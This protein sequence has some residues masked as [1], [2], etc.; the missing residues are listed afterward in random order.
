MNHV[1]NPD[2]RSSASFCFQPRMNNHP[3]SK[4]RFAVWAAALSLASSLHAQTVWTGVSGVNVTTNWSDTANWST[5]ASPAGTDVLFGDVGAVA[6]AG[7][8]NSVVDDSFQNPFSLTFTNMSQSALFHTVFIPSGV[9]LNNAGTFTVGGISAPT[10]TTVANFAGGGTLVQNGAAMNVKWINGTAGGSIATLDL[11]GLSNFVYNAS[12]GIMTIASSASGA[13][14][15][16]GG[17]VTLAGVSNNITVGTIAM[18]LGTGNGGTAANALNLGGGT[19][20]INVGTVNVAAGKINSAVIKFAGAT[21][22]LRLRGV[23]GTDS[24]RANFTLGRRG[25]TG[26]GAINGNVILT[27][28][29]P[30]DILAD[31]MTLGQSTANQGGQTVNGNLAFDAGI[32]D[33]NNINLGVCSGNA[34]AIANGFVTVGG[35]TLKVANFSLVN[36]TLGIAAGTLSITNGGT[37]ICSGSILK[38]TTAGTGTI[39]ID[40]GNLS[41]SNVIGSVSAPVNAMSISNATLTI[42]AGSSA[43]ANVTTL[44][45][46]G[47]TNKINITEIPVISGYPAQFPVIKYAG[48]LGGAFNVGLG[49]LPASAPAFAG[50]I[51]NNTVN[52]SIDLV[53]T[54]GPLPARTISWRGTT[55]GNWDTT[56]P[57][58]FF[59]S[60]TTYN[61]ADFVRFDDAATRT[62][63]ILTTTLLPSSVTVSNQ[64]KAFGFASSGAIS[65]DT[66]LIKDGAATLFITN[67]GL[68][69]FSGTVSILAGTIQVGDGTALGNLGAGNIANSGT[70]TF[71]RPDDVTVANTISGTGALRQHGSAQL[72]V[73]GANTF[74]GNVVV[75]SGTLNT[76][77]NA[78]LGAT[79]GATTINSGATLDVNARNLGA[80]PVTVS[81]VGVGSGGAII[82]SGAQALNALR[83]VT[84]A[85]NT[86]FGGVGRWDIRAAPSTTDPSLA[87]LSTGGN[88]YSLTKIGANQISLVGVTVDPTLGNVD[89]Q[90]GILSLET[91]TT[92]LGNPASSLTVAAGASLQF[93]Q[94]TNQ[95][96][97]VISLASDSFTPSIVNNSGANTIIGPITMTTDCI[98]NVNGTSLNVAGNLSGGIL[99]K[100]GTGTLAIGGAATHAGTVVNVGNLAL[101]GT[102]SGGVTNTSTFAAIS[103][104][105]SA[106]GAVDVSGY[107]FPGASNVVGTLTVGELILQGGGIVGFDL[108]ASTTI[109]SGVN[110]LLVVNGNLTVNGNQININPQGLLQTGVPY[111]LFNYTGTLTE[112]SPFFVPGVNGYTFTVSTATPGQ[113]NLVASGGPPVWNGGSATVN[114]WSDPANWN[115]VT[116]NPND[117]L[118][119]AGSTRLNNINDTT[120]DTTYTDVVFN[121]GAGAFTLNGNSIILAGN[122]ANNSAN[123][124]KVNLG[125]SYNTTPRTLNGGSAGLIIG[126]GV[127]NAA[128]LTTLTLSG[129]GTLTNLLAS[130]DPNTMTNV[131]SMATNAN[132]TL[133]DNATATAVTVP[134]NFQI[135]AGTLNFGS[136]ASAPTLTSTTARGAPGDNSL[137]QTTGAS[138]TL[139][140]NNGILTLSARLNTGAAGGATGIV[141]V[142]NGTLNVDDQV[143]GAN[144]A[145][146]SVSEINVSGGTFNVGGTTV[147]TA[148][149]PLYVASRG[150]GSLTVSGSGALNCGILDV[151]RSI[152]SSI[153]GVVNLDGGTITATRVGT[154]TANAGAA[155]TG[156]TATF[157]FNGGTLKA[158][159]TQAGFIQ[160][161]TAAPIIPVVCIVKSGGAIIDSAGFNVTSVEALQHDS[162]LGGTPDGGLTKNGA[163]TL[164]LTAAS[165]YTGPTVINNGVLAVN[166][167]LATGA[168]S[169]N[170]GGTLAGTGSVGG[171]TTVNAGGAVAPAG[172]G[173]VGTL[174]STANI[175]I[176]GSAILEVNKTAATKDLLTTSGSITYGGTLTVTNLAGTLAAGDSFKVF[177]A[178]SYLGSF[179]TVTAPA[180]GLRWNTSALNTSGTLTAV[181][182]P[183]PNLTSITTSGGNIVLAGNN[184]LPNQ[185]LWVLTST[186][187]SLPLASWTVVTTSNFDGSGNFNI[188]LG[189]PAD[190]QRFYAVQAP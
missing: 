4:T 6:A 85:G 166:G 47:P 87:A 133:M 142:V 43:L 106:A 1:S 69:D 27:G 18:A 182:V 34:G 53:V 25:N 76:L 157:N 11:S 84:L 8:I 167:S 187:V 146:T 180:V 66:A 113:V 138:A 75:Q 104:S 80:E 154:A 111:R 17:V 112:V 9:E 124:Q 103:G 147:G 188:N 137:G 57:N 88:A 159:S 155:T 96:N 28:G 62:E 49:T 93:F 151:S 181:A 41:V 22:G 63:V 121:T 135:A 55:D 64:T 143:Q 102:H 91:A 32:V 105:G 130:A 52:G 23:G 117:T 35:G 10:V 74:T 153:P 160:G 172:F 61:Q 177:N 5:A 31:T 169:V 125:L 77:N 126:G 7:T 15:R 162:A 171:V 54:S 2:G 46:G 86:T 176:S 120:A 38:T 161:S 33:A 119:F 24:D 170:S 97:K 178:A 107:L 141:N 164:T 163:G 37:V 139:N 68:N 129:T 30:V 189:V 95:L 90:Q 81:G 156:S 89:L 60:T 13:E 144:G 110:D 123:V 39:S 101:N 150:P 99:T 190:P 67:S 131:L 19:N 45:C 148:T 127:T 165:T 59:T 132:W 42:A 40:T 92:G 50:Y 174:S 122:V 179:S 109:G 65:G 186:D 168:I 108:T 36:Q 78:A 94:L 100:Q 184:G 26:T 29:H 3:K 149:D 98:F 116:I 82:N 48:V 83:Y 185:P 115:G 136:G 71:N 51:S 44:N 20:I 56:T 79:N 12:S 118:Y 134:W 128:N 14:A 72:I 183:K 73:S 16:G 21:G 114:N 140:V 145:A 158:R 58:W 152:N 173:V 70:L 175:T